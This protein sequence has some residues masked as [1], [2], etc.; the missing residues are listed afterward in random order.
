MAQITEYVNV[1]GVQRRFNVYLPSGHDGS[2]SLPV[3]YHF[4]GGGSSPEEEVSYIDFRPIANAENFIVVYPAGLPAPGDPAP[5]WNSVGPYDHGV[6]DLG[7]VDEMIE[8]MVNEYN[9]D[10]MRMYACGFS[11]GGNFQFDLYCY[12]SE[13]LAAVVAV[14]GGM[15]QWTYDAC[16]PTIPSGIMTIHGTSDSYNPYNGNQYNISFNLLNQYLVQ[17]NGANSSP[18]SETT[19]NRTRYTWEEGEACFSVEH[20]RIQG[21]EHVWPSFATQTIWDFVSNYDLNGVIGCGEETLP[22]DLNGD[23]MVNGAD[24]GLFLVLW[25]SSEEA[26]DLNADGIVNGADLGLLLLY[27]TG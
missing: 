14:A 13:R 20:V 2:E 8:Y 22:G 25:N 10:E 18:T 12:S 1:D 16:N 3:L 24:I 27:W 21:G 7:F 4:H 23:A 6:D 11:V 26:A 19:G 9:A 5:I 17:T 15:W